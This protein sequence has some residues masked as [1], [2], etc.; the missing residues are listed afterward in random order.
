MAVTAPA[1]TANEGLE[2]GLRK[3]RSLWG[4]AWRR[5]LRNRAAVL[6]MI[7]ISFFAVMAIV[8][9][10][11]SNDPTLNIVA[12][13]DLRPPFWVDNPN[14]RKTGTMEYPLGTDTLGR[15][16]FTKLMYGARVSLIVGLVPTLMVVAIGMSIGMAAGYAGGWIDNLLMRL[17]DVV[18]AFPDLLFIIII[19]SAFRDSPLGRPLGG[20]LLLFVSLSIIGWTGMARLIRGQVLSVKEKE[21]VEAARAMGASRGRIML[22]H[23]LP[24][25]FAPVLVF[26][27]FGIPGAII[28]EAALGFF[29]LGLRPATPGTPSTFPT[30]WGVLIQ[31]GVSS[32]QGSPWM[33]IFGATVIGLTVLSFTFI[34]DGLRDALDPRQRD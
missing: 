21:F 16:L 8:A 31:E 22:R 1:R 15:D 18:Y 11:L 2:F 33:L 6:G 9:P 34:G 32:L 20:L 12:R 28:G 17:T 5:L 25:I 29:G 4:D 26:I 23:L 30:S 24:N 3:E 14:P 13:N 27:A 7:I 19:M 10:Y